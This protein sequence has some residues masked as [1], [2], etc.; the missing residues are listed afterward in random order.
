M[1]QI[2]I[3]T[4]ICVWAL[5]VASIVGEAYADPIEQGKI[6]AVTLGDKSFTDVLTIPP[7]FFGPGSSGFC[8][9]IDLASNATADFE[10]SHI[11]GTSE[12]QHVDTVIALEEP[13][14][15]TGMIW[16]HLD[17]LSLVM[18]EPIMIEGVGLI[19]VY[20]SLSEYEESVGFID[21]TVNEAEGGLFD[22]WMDVYAKFTFRAHDTDSYLGEIDVGAPPDLRAV[23]VRG[24]DSI[25]RHDPVPGETIVGDSTANFIVVQFKDDE[26][27]IRSLRG[28]AGSSHGR[29]SAAS[30][31]GGA[32]SWGGLE[33]TDTLTEAEC[34]DLGGT[35]SADAT[36]GGSGIITVT[37]WGLVVP[38]PHRAARSE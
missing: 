28:C 7:D 6:Y 4:V 18:P 36:C 2:G 11:F 35:F 1:N 25:W 22:T 12:T 21:V 9:C 14:S 38:T 19:D 33:C 16:A 32:C 15:E 31:Q 27:F 26:K 37:E 10:N 23:E 29:L 13:L 24:H 8:G 17:M 34:F 3:K 5:S 30:T 20:V